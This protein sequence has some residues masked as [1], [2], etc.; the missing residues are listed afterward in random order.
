[1]RTTILIPLAISI[2]I[3]ASSCDN[4]PKLVDFTLHPSVQYAVEH[5]AGD[6]SSNS[7]YLFCHLPVNLPSGLQT[8]DLYHFQM[9]GHINRFDSEGDWKDCAW[10]TFFKFDL[11]QLP[12]KKVVA[13]TLHVETGEFE[14]CQVGTC[15]NSGSCQTKLYSANVDVDPAKYNYNLPGDYWTTFQLSYEGYLDFAMGA[16]VRQWAQNS[17]PNHGLFLVGIENFGVKNNITCWVHVT[18]ISLKVTVNTN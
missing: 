14:M 15:S 16:E 12:S 6:A 4:K 8:N 17:K 1:M 7:D 9:V 18:D 11:S 13:A 10:R 2:I 3:S 5:S